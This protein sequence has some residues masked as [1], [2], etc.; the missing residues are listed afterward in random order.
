MEAKASEAVQMR[1][2]G[3]MSFAYLHSVRIARLSRVN[4]FGALQFDLLFSTNSTICRQKRDTP[5][6][7]ETVSKGT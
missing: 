7:K 4:N 2:F 1:R 6:P 3:S 5:C